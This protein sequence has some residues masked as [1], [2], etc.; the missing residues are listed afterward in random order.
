MLLTLKREPSTLFYTEGK[1]FLGE[2]YLCDTLEN[3][4]RPIFDINDKIQ[5]YTAIPAG[6]YRISWTYSKKFKKHMPLLEQVPWFSGIRIH[7][8]NTVRDTAG[9]I[10]VGRKCYDG[11]LEHSRVTYASIAVMI[12]SAILKGEKVEIL[13]L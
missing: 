6:R 10:L 1:L 2:K 13:I 9:C 4:V 3:V 11:M 5:G 12:S 8:G 7:S